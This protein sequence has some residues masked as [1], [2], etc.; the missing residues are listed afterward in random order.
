[1][2]DNAPDLPC[3]NGEWNRLMADWN[4][5][6]KQRDIVDFIH[7]LLPWLAPHTAAANG[8]LKQGIVKIIDTGTEACP[9]HLYACMS[10][11][12]DHVDLQLLI[13]DIG[14]WVH[15]DYIPWLVLETS[16][17][18]RLIDSMPGTLALRHFEDTTGLLSLSAVAGGG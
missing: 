15:T 6:F 3:E 8:N 16:P 7:Y 13:A 9:V 14:Q 5:P 18:F 1:N 11:E 2:A 12:R 17:V 10:P 4:H